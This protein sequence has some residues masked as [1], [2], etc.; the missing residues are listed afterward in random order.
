MKKAGVLLL[1]IC[2]L[3]IISGQNVGADAAIDWY[4]SE[5]EVDYDVVV[6]APDGGVNIRYGPGVE[7]EKLQEDMIPNGVQLHLMRQ[8]QASNGNY[9]GYTQYNGLYGWIALTQV[10]E[11]T[12]PAAETQVPAETPLPEATAAPEPTTE[13]TQPPAVTETVTETPTPK[14]T[15]ENTETPT[16]RAAPAQENQDSGLSKSLVIKLMVIGFILLVIAVAALVI[17]YKRRR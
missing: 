10:T 9:W 15:I 8:A 3:T 5:S 2:F 12:S 6:S 16:P 17:L 7:Y 13:I 4:P 11:I 1:M 14:P